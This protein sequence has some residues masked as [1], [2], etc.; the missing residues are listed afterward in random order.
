MRTAQPEAAAS[1]SAL[2]SSLLRS[3]TAKASDGPCSSLICVQCWCTLLW[4]VVWQVHWFVP[5]CV[6]RPAALACHWSG[7]A[8]GSLTTF[9]AERAGRC[10]LSTSCRS[11]P[12]TSPASCGKCMQPWLSFPVRSA[13]RVCGHLPEPQ[14][15]HPAL[16]QGTAQRADP[17][18][19]HAGAPARLL[20]S[21][22]L[23]QHHVVYHALRPPRFHVAPSTETDTPGTCT[24][25]SA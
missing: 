9:R 12:H 17:G 19:P 24:P 3:A 23:T 14:A 6:S 18:L 11:V 13:G 16:H 21:S 7:A 4:S 10:P 2:K 20:A 22:L 5:S 1:K 15:L 25:S 8:C